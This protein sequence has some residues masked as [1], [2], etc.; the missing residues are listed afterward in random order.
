MGARPR[1]RNVLAHVRAVRPDI[2]DPV[3]A[4]RERRLVVGGVVML[5]PTSTVRSDAGVV[6]RRARRLRGSVKLAAA[7]DAFRIDVTG[8]AC[9]DVGAAAGGF[10]TVLLERGARLVYALD[11]GFGQL[12]G[13]L[14]SDPRVVSLE[15]TNL[16]N[17][18]R[19]IPREPPI[20]LVTVDLSYLSLREA[21]PQL[22]Y[23]TFAPT[24]HLVALV[25]PMFE[26]TLDRAPRDARSLGQARARA[27]EAARGA[28]WGG[29]EVVTSPVRGANGTVEFFLHGRYRGA[30]AQEEALGPLADGQPS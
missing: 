14:R 5:E 21:L 20:E 7:L 6:L 18:W 27:S 15:R 12:R 2:E 29:A 3:A 25:K 10:T 17:A 23:L 19:V 4:I 8:R 13:S 26:L 9:L 16:A 22:T 30:P 11:A 1:F 24:A 28:G